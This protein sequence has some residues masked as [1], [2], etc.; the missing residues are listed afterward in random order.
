MYF[1][2]PFDETG[3]VG[4]LGLLVLIAAVLFLLRPIRNTKIVVACLMIGWGI[5]F[6]AS[7]MEITWFP[8]NLHGHFSIETKG[9]VL[10]ETVGLE[11][12]RQK[13]ITGLLI[14]VPVLIAIGPDSRKALIR[15]YRG[16]VIGLIIAGV[17]IAALCAFSWCIYVSWPWS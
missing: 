16:F 8:K 7:A 11:I 3:Y 10:L 12:G 6:L 4:A 1:F 17:D 14:T 15:P 13:I 9:L 5:L 2:R